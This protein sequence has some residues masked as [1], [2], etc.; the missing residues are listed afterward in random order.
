MGISRNERATP[1]RADSSTSITLAGSVSSARRKP[2]GRRTASRAAVLRAKAPSHFTGHLVDPHDRAQR[3][4]G[5]QALGTRRP[6]VFLR[7]ASSRRPR[8]W[9]SAAWW[10][11]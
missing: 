5:G 11:V 1:S 9:S 4:V 6:T 10:W 8:E 2:L 3:L 7:I